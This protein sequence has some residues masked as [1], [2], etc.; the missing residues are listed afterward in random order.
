MTD[1]L[2]AI[3]GGMLTLAG[4]ILLYLASPHQRLAARPPRGRALADAGVCALLGA[5]ALL[6]GVAGTA[7]AVFVWLT[8]AM[9]LWSIVPLAA[10]WARRP[11][12][13]A[14]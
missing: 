5:L 8:L 13:N 3:G 1:L 11:R 4:T 6:L 14:R 7:T 10:A 2:L 9:A 12:E